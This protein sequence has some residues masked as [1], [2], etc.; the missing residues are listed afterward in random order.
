MVDEA[1]IEKLAALSHISLSSEERK[2]LQKDIESILSYVERIQSVSAGSAARLTKAP[3]RT[4]MREDGEPHSAGLYTTPLLEAA[5]RT[6]NNFI[7]VKK[8]IDQ[9]DRE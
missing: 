8:I 6:K 4:V 9:A 5:P 7:E 1:H 2:R 3:V